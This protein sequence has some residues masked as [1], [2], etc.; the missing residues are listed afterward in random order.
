MICK[1]NTTSITNKDLV[2][3][4]TLVKAYP[5]E[6]STL[7]D[8]RPTVLEISYQE[9]TTILG[10]VLSNTPILDGTNTAVEPTEEFIP[11]V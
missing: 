7:L 1:K 11:I 6:I 3:V 4:P 5:T 8:V 2:T 10:A 9:A